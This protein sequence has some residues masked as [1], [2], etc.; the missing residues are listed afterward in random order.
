[1]WSKTPNE[2]TEDEVIFFIRHKR[3]LLALLPNYEETLLPPGQ[4]QNIVDLTASL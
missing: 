4:A 1:M 2:V 3:A